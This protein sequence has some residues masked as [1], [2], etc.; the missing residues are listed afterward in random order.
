MYW[1][2]ALIFTPLIL[3]AQTQSE[4][5]SYQ[6][7]QLN[8]FNSRP[9][10]KLS[11]EKKLRKFAKIDKDEAAKIAIKEC[12]LKKRGYIRLKRYG[13]IIYYEMTSPNGRVKINAL[14]GKVITC[15][16]EK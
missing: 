5:N 13:R 15:G 3:G 1:F 4:L 12:N 10:V 16:G 9:L 6:M 14:D 11:D 8:R 2:I 7:G